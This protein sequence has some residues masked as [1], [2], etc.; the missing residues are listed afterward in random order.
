MPMHRKP[1]TPE[2]AQSQWHREAAEIYRQIDDGKRLHSRAA[3]MFPA[4]GRRTIGAVPQQQAAQ[5]PNAASRL[6]P[7][8]PTNRR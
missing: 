5:K 8:L 3:K 1:V 4:L 7:R 2:Q 6:Y